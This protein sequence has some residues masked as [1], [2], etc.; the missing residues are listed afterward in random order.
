MA[1]R[2]YTC[3]EFSFW[4]DFVHYGGAIGFL[5]LNDNIPAGLS[6]FTG[7]V[8]VITGFAG[9]GATL[10]FGGSV[11]GAFSSNLA[12]PA[13]NT[14]NIYI[15]TFSGNPFSSATQNLGIIIAGAPITAGR[16]IFYCQGVPITET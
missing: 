8:H 4:Y 6:F 14:G 10:A 15:P 13:L 16:G 11:D 3:T 2:G 7:F 5:N 9:V 12:V 1:R